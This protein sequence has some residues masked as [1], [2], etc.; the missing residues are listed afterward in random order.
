[1]AFKIIEINKIIKYSP[2]QVWSIVGKVDRFDWVPGIESISIEDDCR[3]FLLKSMGKIKERIL[4]KDDDIF[5]L[6]YQ[7]IS[8]PVPLQHH[9]ASINLSKHKKGCIFIWKTEIDPPEFA[10][11]I[12]KSMQ[13]S[14]DMICDILQKEFA[15]Q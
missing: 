12:Y 13:D 14:F 7:A 11:L 4:V 6:N 3:I 9:L 8:S 2:E 1:M 10:D 5:K 15:E